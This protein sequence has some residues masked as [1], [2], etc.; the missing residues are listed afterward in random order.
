LPGAMPWNDVML[1]RRW[2]NPIPISRRVCA[3]KMLRLLPL[4]IN[5]LENRELPMT[6]STTSGYWPGLGMRFG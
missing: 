5:T 6:G 2:S 1:G 4:S 3:Y